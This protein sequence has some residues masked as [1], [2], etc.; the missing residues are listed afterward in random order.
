MSEAMQEA[1][2][3]GYLAG[4]GAYGWWKDG[5]Q[6]VGTCGTTLAE[7]TERAKQEY[8]VTAEDGRE[9]PSLSRPGW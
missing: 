3:K 8:V 6:Y 2:L 4:L 5:V 7:A 9:K 1:W